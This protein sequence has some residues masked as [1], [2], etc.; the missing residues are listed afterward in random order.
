M[1]LVVVV[2]ILKGV[3]SI[4]IQIGVVDDNPNLYKSLGVTI[5]PENITLWLLT[6][7]FISE[8]V[9]LIASILL[10]VG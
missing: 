5:G 10:F 4:M 1:L 7:T 8:V 2:L 3:L 6:Q 9:T